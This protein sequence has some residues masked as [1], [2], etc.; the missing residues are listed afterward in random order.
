MKEQSDQGLHSVIL[1]LPFTHLIRIMLRRSGPE[2]VKLISY[3]SE[4]KSILLINVKIPT[5]V[6]CWHFNIYEQD[7]Y[8]I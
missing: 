2:V 6:G 8:N 5:I 1:F 4:M 7:K 3:S